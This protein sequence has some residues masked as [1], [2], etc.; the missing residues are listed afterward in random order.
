MKRL[1][2]TQLATLAVIA[3]FAGG[4]LA[5]IP[6]EVKLGTPRMGEITFDHKLHQG[7]GECAVCHHKGVEKAACRACHGADAALPDM[8]TVSHA[9]CRDC[10]KKQGAPTGCRDC[11]KK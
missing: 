4:A 3:V 8:K 11:H 1:L 10:H 9:M 6:T 7:V 2:I 5:A